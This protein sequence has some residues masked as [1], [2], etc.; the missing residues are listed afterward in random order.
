M[1]LGFTNF[2][3]GLNLDPQS[4]DPSTPAEGDQ[5]YSDGTARAKGMWQYKD[6]NWAEF[7]GS[8]S[9]GINYLAGDSS[10]AENS[11][12]D[13]LAY[14]DAAATTPVDGTGGSPTVTV[15]QNLTTPL[16]GTADILITKDAAN[17]QGEGDGVAFTT[18]LADKA[19]KLTIK[20]DYTTSTNYADDDIK[21]FVYDVTNTNLIRVNGEGLKA[22]SGNGTHYAQFQTAS[23]STS[24]R[25]ILHVSST[26]AL[27]YTVNLDNISVGPTNLAFGAT[28]IDP[29]DFIPSFTT[30]SLGNGTVD[31]SVTAAVGDNIIFCGIN[32]VNWEAI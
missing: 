8:G 6:G 23:D 19:K 5:F 7:G 12:G 32:S 30:F 16:R 14:A 3:K 17:R 2:K 28:V 24:Y 20:F 4:A 26:N 10:D 31:A 9:S 25:L 18:D 13:H 22:T 29:I 21:V 15:A 27:A 1:S 11:V